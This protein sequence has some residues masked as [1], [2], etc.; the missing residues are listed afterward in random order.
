[1]QK[2]EKK[3]NRLMH[4]G[5]TNN[6]YSQMFSDRCSYYL[7]RENRVLTQRATTYRFI[8]L[9]V[10]ENRNLLEIIDFLLRP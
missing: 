6:F 7:L 5:H 10:Y 1:M 4:M 2:Q 8:K 3:G 9:Y